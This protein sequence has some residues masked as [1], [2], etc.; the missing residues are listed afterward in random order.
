MPDRQETLIA[1][2]IALLEDASGMPLKDADRQASLVEL[3]LDSLLLT[4]IALSLSKKYGSKVTF[5]QL[6]GELSSL[7]KL[8]RHFDQILPASASTAPTPSATPP[9]ASQVAAPAQA[10]VAAPTGEL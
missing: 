6:N 3:G 10:G 4:Q 7:S 5:R 9:M 1:E 2:I 8:A